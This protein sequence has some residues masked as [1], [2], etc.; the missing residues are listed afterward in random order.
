M[1]RLEHKV[2]GLSETVASLSRDLQIYT[3]VQ[4]EKCKTWEN[5]VEAHDKLLYGKNLDSGTDSMVDRIKRLE[6]KAQAIWLCIGYCI[7]KMSPLLSKMV[8]KVVALF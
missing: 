2:D 1:V 5:R 7:A 6:Y 8:D 3:S 4:T